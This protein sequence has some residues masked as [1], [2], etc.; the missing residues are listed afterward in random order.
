[1]DKKLHIQLNKTKS[2]HINFTK[3]RFEHI[4]MRNLQGNYKQP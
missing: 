4:P 1:M 3:R 2:V